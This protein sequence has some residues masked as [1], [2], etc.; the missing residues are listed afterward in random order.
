VSAAAEPAPDSWHAELTGAFFVAKIYAVWKH[1]KRLILVFTYC[2]VLFTF[3]LL[4]KSLISNE[5]VLFVI[6]YRTFR[7]QTFRF[8]KIV[9]LYAQLIAKKSGVHW[10]P[11]RSVGEKVV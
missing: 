5:K 6:C 10:V 4:R 1:K 9:V 7:P 11:V 3:I 8:G 2:A